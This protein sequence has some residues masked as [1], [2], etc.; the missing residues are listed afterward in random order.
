MS[1]KSKNAVASMVV[2]L[3]ILV[4]YAV[5]AAREGGAESLRWWAS[6]ALAFLG[7][8]VVALILVQIVFRIVLAASFAAR[9]DDPRRVK[10]MLSSAMAE[11]EMDRMLGL[12]AARVGY[13]CAGVGLVGMLATLAFGGSA[14]LA[15][16]VL[17]GS[18]ALGSLVAG[19]VSVHGYER[20]V[21]N[22]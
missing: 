11:D 4:G 3:A 14:V 1:P 22:G 9:E 6:T 21:R 5:Y 16:H 8:A 20:G 17:L 2:G 15:L 18:F 19:A 13:A 12:R 7:I 10:R